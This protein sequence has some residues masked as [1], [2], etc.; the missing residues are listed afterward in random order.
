M[1]VDMQYPDGKR[2]YFYVSS[3]EF[4][5][6]SAGEGAASFVRPQKRRTPAA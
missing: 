4:L 6:M 2:G 3:D 1:I 5:P